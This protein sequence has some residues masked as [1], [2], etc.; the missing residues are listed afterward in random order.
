MIYL[1]Y[2]VHQTV[3]YFMRWIFA[4]F[5]SVRTLPQFAIIPSIFRNLRIYVTLNPLDV[6]SFRKQYYAVG[7]ESTSYHDRNDTRNCERD[8]FRRS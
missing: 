8:C 6:C 2:M 1:I 4:D 5:G 3:V 7:S